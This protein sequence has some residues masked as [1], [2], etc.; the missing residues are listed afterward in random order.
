MGISEAIA[1]FII[2]ITKETST[3]FSNLQLLELSTF[4]IVLDVLLVTILFYFIFVLIRGTRA[5]HIMLGLIIIA[6]LYLVSRVLSLFAMGWLLDRFF[7]LVIVAIPIIFQQEL[8]RGLERLGQT[9]LRHRQIKKAA[10]IF[11]GNVTEACKE[12]SKRKKGGLIVFKQDISLNEYAETGIKLNA[13]LSKELLLSIFGAKMPLHDGAVIIEDFKIKAASCLLPHSASSPSGKFGTRH[14]AALG[15]SENTD[16]F[17]IVISEENGQI[18]FVFD[19]EMERGIKEEKLTQLL[20]KF[21][22]KK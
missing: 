11:I 22:N 20:T 10:D 7:T 19:G 13:D 15:I 16:A 6:L 1:N 9:K 3:F 18:S 12:L 21:L 4:Q 8:R 5:F 14:K 2:F 17:V